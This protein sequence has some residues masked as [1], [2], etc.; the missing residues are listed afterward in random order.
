MTFSFLNVCFQHLSNITLEDV[1]T[2]QL[3]K[4]ASFNFRFIYK[5]IKY[6]DLKNDVCYIMH[7][8]NFE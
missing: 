3:S 4:S 2:E 1:K 5:K 8:L 7:K 6:G